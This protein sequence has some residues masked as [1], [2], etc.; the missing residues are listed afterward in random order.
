M[1]PAYVNSP[2]HS[3]KV[4]AWGLAW[5]LPTGPGVECDWMSS[6]TSLSDKPLAHPWAQ[7]K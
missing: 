4:S 3:F 7:C 1:K 2:W 5:D 6:M